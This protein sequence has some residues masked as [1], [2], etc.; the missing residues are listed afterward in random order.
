M[1]NLKTLYLALPFE[2]LIA[3]AAQIIALRWALRVRWSDFRLDAVGG[4]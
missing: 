2:F 1:H 4:D 3:T